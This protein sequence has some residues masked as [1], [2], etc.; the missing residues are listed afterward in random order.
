MRIFICIALIIF[1]SV[2]GLVHAEQKEAL[3]FGVHPFKN[4]RQ[5]YRMFKPITQY[6]SEKAHRPVKI[7]IGKSY[8]DI[9]S[10][11]E[12]GLVDFGYF[13]PVPYVKAQ[14]LTKIIPLARIQNNGRGAFRGAI[15]VKAD[16][17]IKSL[18]QLKGKSFA[19]GDPEST[20]SHYVPHYMLMQSGVYL[21]DLSNYI[22]T[23]SHD[24]VAGNV[25]HGIVEAGGLKP[26]I[27]KKYLE[28]G[29]KILTRS[30]WIPEHLFAANSNLNKEDIKLLKNILLNADISTLKAIKSSI[31]GMEPAKSSDYDELRKIMN[32]VNTLDP[33][34]PTSK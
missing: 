24:N 21:E 23:S 29:L 17:K 34:S 25:L 27:A 18:N 20:L 12:Q 4:P 3:I 14:S 31:T 6:I 30:P 5:I 13:G 11:H 8:E 26:T 28:R 19:F 1:I 32:D 16:S 15:V 2:S 22:F 33:I 10:K 7:V 9:I